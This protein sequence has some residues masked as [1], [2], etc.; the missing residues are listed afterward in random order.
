MTKK[1]NPKTEPAYLAGAVKDAYECLLNGLG[2]SHI[3]TFRMKYTLTCRYFNEKMYEE[4]YQLTEGMTDE[5]VSRLDELEDADNFFDIITFRLVSCVETGRFDEAIA[6]GE[7]TLPILR[8]KFRADVIE[9]ANY[10]ILLCDAYMGKGMYAE[11]EKLLK[12]AIAKMDEE[13]IPASEPIY[14]T[15]AINWAGCLNALGRVVTAREV[16]DDLRLLI[17]EEKDENE[18]YIL[19]DL[20]DS[21][22]DAPPAFIDFLSAGIAGVITDFAYEKLGSRKPFTFSSILKDV[23]NSP[24]LESKLFD[25]AS[26]FSYLVDPEGDEEEFLP[27][28]DEED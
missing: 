26:E 16:L 19:E 21:S 10:S 9:L 8:K 12:K 18:D 17:D 22:E 4:L 23:Q 25:L 14:C 1:K 13:D 7:K 6:E 11:G 20:A 15:A 27:Y 3:M 24:E 2:E 5:A 28:P